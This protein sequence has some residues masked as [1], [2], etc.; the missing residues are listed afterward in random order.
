M[1]K[2][3]SLAA[4]FLMISIISVP[5]FTTGCGH[6]PVLP[7]SDPNYRGDAILYQAERT[8]VNAYKLMDAFATWE[9]NFRSVLPVEVSRAA[10]VMRKNGRNWIN[11]AIAARDAYAAS[12]GDPGKKDAL[13]TALNVIDVALS[14]AAIYMADNKKLAPNNGLTPQ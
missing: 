3:N 6:T 5:I 14:Q 8:T 12:P 11:T 1:K 4:L 10:D 13:N 7:T 9:L 2:L